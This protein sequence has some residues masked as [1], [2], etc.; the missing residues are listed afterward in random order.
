MTNSGTEN[1][2]AAI[3]LA[4]FHTGRTQFIG[5]TED[6]TVEHQAHWLLPRENQ[7]IDTV[8]SQLWAVFFMHHILIHIEKSHFRNGEPYGETVVRYTEEESIGK[9]VPANDIAGIL[10]EP[11]QGEG[12]YVV[13]AEGFFPAL[14]KLCDK[15]GILLIADEVQSGMGRTGKWWAV[16]HFGVQPDIICAAKGIASAIPLGAMI[17]KGSI[18][19]WPAGSHGNTFG[20]N[21]IASAAALATIELI[22]KGYLKNAV[23]H[24]ILY[25]RCLGRNQDKS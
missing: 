1:V 9:L 20:G 21:P 2:E 3:K 4:K 16:E 7:N 15:H 19:D 25:D 14:R 6:F 13:P 12:G 17:A 5:F 8:F 22:E 24:G 18:M 11:I 10:V 23:R